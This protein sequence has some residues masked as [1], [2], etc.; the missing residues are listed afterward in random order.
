MRPQIPRSQE[1]NAAASLVVL[2]SSASGFRTSRREHAYLLC[3]RWDNEFA[4][5]GE[6]CTCTARDPGFWLNRIVLAPSRH[7][8]LGFRKFGSARRGN[9]GEGAIRLTGVFSDYRLTGFDGQVSGHDDLPVGQC[10]RAALFEGWSVDEV[11][12][13]VEVVVDVGVDGCELL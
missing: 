9:G 4:V 13:G 7:W 5:L 2:R 11:T 8:C 3:D 1:L 6:S 12:F 10:T